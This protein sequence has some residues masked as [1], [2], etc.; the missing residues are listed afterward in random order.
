MSATSHPPRRRFSP[1]RSPDRLPSAAPDDATPADSSNFECSVCLR[2]FH[3]PTTLHC[4][5]SFCRR[6]V[7]ECMRHAL[8]CP[9]CRVDVP[10]DE[11]PQVSLALQ[12]ALTRLFPAAA[13]QRAAEEASA[14]PLVSLRSAGMPALPLFV[15]EPLLPGQVMQLHIFEPR[16]ILLVQRVLSRPA[17]DRCFGMVSLRSAGSA[18][19]GHGVSARITACTEAHGGRFFVT[20][21]GERRF[22]ILRTWDVDGYRTAHVA[23]A[24]DAALPTDESAAAAGGESGGGEA[25]SSGEGASG[26]ESRGGGGGAAR[27][28]RAHVG[29]SLLARELCVAL[30]DWLSAVQ[31]GGWERQTGQVS[32]CMSDLGPMPRAEEHEALGLWAA[33]LLNPLPALGVAPEIRQRALDATDSLTR[34]ADPLL[35]RTSRMPSLLT[36]CPLPH[37]SPGCASSSRPPSSRCSIYTRRGSSHGAARSPRAARCSSCC[38]SH[39]WRRCPSVSTSTTQ[40]TTPSSELLRWG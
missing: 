37:T 7:V 29:A 3:A 39:S 38:R 26:G 11:A 20:I 1:A 5:H 8:K 22:R 21:K 17:L 36:V 32:R 16:Y 35:T 27:P 4:G 6:C 40:P 15:L 31:S 19:S 33:A 28:T 9:T 25:G 14:P 23:W 13:A 24:S 30:G 12:D 10:W 18:G 2:L 34:C